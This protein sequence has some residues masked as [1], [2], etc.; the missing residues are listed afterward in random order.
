M[1]S[2][3]KK[4]IRREGEAANGASSSGDRKSSLR[5]MEVNMVSSLEKKV[6]N[7]WPAVR[8]A[9]VQIPARHPREVLPLSNEE[10]GERPRRMEMDE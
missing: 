2:R 3:K 8:Q 6:R 10:T 1:F 4:F 7:G 5:R 9:R